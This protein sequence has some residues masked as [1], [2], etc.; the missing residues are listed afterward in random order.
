MSEGAS[1]ADVLDELRSRYPDF[2]AGLRGR[3]L[4]R[5]SDKVLYSL[6]L[7]AKYIPFK[8]A[9]TAEVHDGD[10]VF[11]FLPVAGG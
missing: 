3:G 8:E 5:P 9:G 4:H 10:R 1:V 11:L 2:E 6:F 7:N